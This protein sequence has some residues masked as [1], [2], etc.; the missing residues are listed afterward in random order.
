MEGTF[1]WPA[2]AWYAA[3]TVF[4]NFH[5]MHARSF[6]GAS[7]NF[8][9]ALSLSSMLGFVVGVVYLLAYGWMISW[10][11]A[12]GLVALSFLARVASITLELML[13]QWVLSLV[14]FVGWPLCAYFMFRQLLGG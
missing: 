9:T 10:L 4:L 6:R 7:R 3:F 13:E 1:S 2:A 14:A 8:A 5:L 11:V 12:A